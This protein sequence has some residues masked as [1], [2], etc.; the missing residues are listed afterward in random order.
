MRASTGEVSNRADNERFAGLP[1]VVARYLDRAIPFAVRVPSQVRVTQTG[2]L[3]SKPKGRPMHVTA[4]ERFAVDRTAFC[5]DARFR[6][7]PALALRVRD[8]YEAGQGSLSLRAFGLRIQRRSGPELAVAEAYRYLAEL[9][10]APHAMAANH[11][12]EWQELDPRT[13]EVCC[14]VGGERLTVVF[15]YDASGDIFSCSAAARPREDG[16]RFVPTAWGGEFSD[17]R[18]LGAVRLPTRAEVYWDLPEGRFVYWH[19][20]IT[21]VTVT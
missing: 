12:L 10:W 2:V 3:W 13:A 19:G 5:W 7:A 18:T 4:E 9:P 16:R 1:T 8:C 15:E 20:R 21:E 11:E 6:L 17:Y 14:R